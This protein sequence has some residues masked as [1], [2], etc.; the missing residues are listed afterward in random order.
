MTTVL[1]FQNLAAL[2]MAQDLGFDKQR[3]FK[4]RE[5]H[6]FS[7]L[8]LVFSFPLTNSSVKTWTFARIT[9]CLMPVLNPKISTFKP[10]PSSHT[11]LFQGG[12]NFWSKKTFY[13]FP[14]SL[15]VKGSHCG[16][17]IKS[18]LSSSKGL[19]EL[20]NFFFSHSLFAFILLE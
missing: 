4:Y 9:H 19:E 16:P 18:H 10:T 2:P 20:S 12:L 6:T 5:I 17:R 7:S 3:I 8:A 11:F 13:N 14:D 1:F 15:A